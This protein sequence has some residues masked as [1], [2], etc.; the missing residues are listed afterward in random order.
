MGLLQNTTQKEYYESKDY[1]GYQFVSLED[2]INQ[3]MVVYVGEDKIINKA[4]KTDVQFHG[5][6]ALQELSFDTFKSIKSQEIVLP[7]SLTMPLPHDYVNYVKLTWVDSSGIEHIIY[8]AIKTS[9]PLKLDQ[10]DDGSYIFQAD[11]NLVINGDFESTLQDSPWT[12]STIS[13]NHR[14]GGFGSLHYTD[15]TNYPFTTIPD[16]IEIV[17]GKLSITTNNFWYRG[18]VASRAYA[19]WQEIDVSAYNTIAISAKA[20]SAAPGTTPIHGNGIIKLGLSTVPGSNFTN[21]YNIVNSNHQ[22]NV[23]DPDVAVITWDDGN[24]TETEKELTDINVRQ[25]DKLFVVVQMRTI[26]T[27]LGGGSGTEYF[28]TNTIDDIVVEFDGDA[29]SLKV[30]PKSSTTRDNFKSLTPTDLEQDNYD[31]GTYDLIVGNKYGIDPQFTQVNGSFFIDELR[32]N[33]HFASN[34]SGKTIILK[35]ISDGV[36]KDDEMQVHKFAEEA[37][38]KYISHAILSGKKNIP[39]YIINRFKRE[40]FAAIRNAKLRL[41]NVKLEEITQVLRGKSKWIKH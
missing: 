38:Y 33:I 21:P 16:K 35:Y 28:Q 8:P 20:T 32:G 22:V 5:Q 12:F 14:A 1:G 4:R 39:E 11:E 15:P 6:R 25:Y 10:E 37:M 13:S 41:S 29:G 36:G 18:A 27:Q 9:N 40:K 31:D 7:P 17:N 3:F 24:A 34:I 2:I 19:C 23:T 30:D 26:W